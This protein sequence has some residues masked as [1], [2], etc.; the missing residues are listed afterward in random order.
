MRV[1]V[2]AVPLA[3]NDLQFSSVALRRESSASLTLTFTPSAEP[4]VAFQFDLDYDPA[5]MQLTSLAGEAIRLAG[6]SLFS[7]PID[8][9]T[10]RFMVTGFNQS[11]IPTGPVI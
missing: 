3:A 6:K 5:A 4:M 11:P 2:V 9:R 8:S 10:T 1:V 7:A